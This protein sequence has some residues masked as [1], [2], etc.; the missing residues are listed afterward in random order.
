MTG[1]V[2][3]PD[4]APAPNVCVVASGYQVQFAAGCGASGF[5][6]QWWQDAPKRAAAKVITV[7][8]GG[9]TSGISA[10]LRH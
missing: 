6:T 3:E 4:G 5:A 8:A 9:M 1:L 10:V 7:A 2:R